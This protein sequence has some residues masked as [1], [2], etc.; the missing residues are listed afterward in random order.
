MFMSTAPDCKLYG[1]R[2]SSSDIDNRRVWNFLV[3]G[4]RPRPEQTWANNAVDIF[5]LLFYVSF[6]LMS[7]FST[8]IYR[9]PI[10]EKVTYWISFIFTQGPVNNATFSNWLNKT[11]ISSL[12][13]N[14][15]QSHR[16]YMVPTFK[17][18]YY[19]ICQPYVNSGT[20]W[21]PTLL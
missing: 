10:Q 21:V 13:N 12:F 20:H 17:V 19:Y 4:V 15:K 7:M 14:Y 18:E 9:P 16:F 1:N 3:S 5:F 6:W 8:L 11:E 2:Q